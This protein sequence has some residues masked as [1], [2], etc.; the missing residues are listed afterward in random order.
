MTVTVKHL[1]DSPK[2]DG[3]DNTLIQ[4][5]DWN[6]NHVLTGIGT[7]AEQNAATVAITGGTIDGVAITGG[8]ITNI[9]DLAVADGGTGASNAAA[10]RSNLGLGTIA[11]QSSSAV[12][13]TGGSITN[14]TDLAI[15]DGGTGASDSASARTNLN[16]YSKTETDTVAATAV[17]SAIGTTVQA[18]DTNTAKLTSVQSWSAKQTFATTVKLQQ[19][20]EKVNTIAAAPTAT[21]TF[22]VLT[23]GIQYHTV[24][25]TANW[26]LNIRGDGSNTLNTVMAVGDLIT[27]RMY[28]TNGATGYLPT[29]FQIDG[30][31]V[32]MKLVGGT[33]WTA[34]ASCIG[35]YEFQIIKTAA[36]TFTLM[37]TKT[38]FV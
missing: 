18:F 16:I 3:P 23:A 22:D 34:D 27:L 19:T 12:S 33:S 37:G 6:A 17:S 21:Q 36:A 28:V 38:K 11:T 1:F 24:N 29:T 26:T 30:S 2:N 13:I 31:G 9:T 35:L 7:M 8:S 15:A 4:P 10:A 5:S 14:I 32:T 20:L 25:S